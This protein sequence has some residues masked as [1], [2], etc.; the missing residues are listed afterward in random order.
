MDDKFRKLFE[1]QNR[2]QKLLEDAAG[3]GARLWKQMEKLLE[4]SPAQMSIQKM[5]ADFEASPAHEQLREQVERINQ[6][7]EPLRKQMESIRKLHESLGLDDGTLTAMRQAADVI[8][9]QPIAPLPAR[10]V[11]PPLPKITPPE[12]PKSPAVRMLETIMDEA[13]A[14]RAEKQDQRHTVFVMVYLPDGTRILVDQMSTKDGQV[15]H[16]EGTDPKSKEPRSA[17]VGAL[18]FQYDF[19]TIEHPPNL[20]LVE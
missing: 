13:D 1:Q 5:L 14:E 2:F 6:M 9:E 15:I 19:I 3:P 20:Y 11:E 4:P 12:P 8:R 17:K 16:I 10:I 7:G 18:G